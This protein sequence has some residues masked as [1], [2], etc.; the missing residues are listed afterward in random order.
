[1]ARKAFI[2]LLATKLAL[3]RILF[4][5]PPPLT[6]NSFGSP[7]KQKYSVIGTNGGAAKCDNCPLGLCPLNTYLDHMPKLPSSTT[8]F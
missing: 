2:Q 8:A 7:M 4:L 6:A 5:W 3:T 1:M